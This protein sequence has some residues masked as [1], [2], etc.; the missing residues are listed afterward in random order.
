MGIKI[1]IELSTQRLLLKNNQNT[2]STYP[3]AIGK[4]STP[5]PTGDFNI[6]SKVKNPGGVLGTR[7]MKFTWREHGIHGT[8]QPGSIGKAIS[9][10]CVR[11]YN[12]D[13]ETVYSK[14]SIDTPVII[15]ESFNKSIQGP[16]KNY[17]IYTVKKGDSL[18]TISKKFKISIEDIIKLNNIEND[19][20]YP[21]D[22]LKIP[23]RQ[24]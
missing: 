17:I 24:H 12:E 10:G 23:I 7:W 9:L 21:D 4:S 3:V 18:W 6:L 19:T 16:E 22:R 1:N 13:V 8:N 15:R 5:T 11:M 14:V 20:I 2:I